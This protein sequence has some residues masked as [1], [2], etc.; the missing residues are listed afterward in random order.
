MRGP[1]RPEGCDDCVRNSYCWISIAV[2][3]SSKRTTRPRATSFKA[4]LL[5]SCAGQL[6]DNSSRRPGSRTCS[7][8]N[9]TPELDI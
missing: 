1:R 8:V 4:H 3:P 5:L 6:I 9:K 7:E 2:R